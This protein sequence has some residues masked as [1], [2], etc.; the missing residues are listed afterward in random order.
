MNEI[1][2]V[3]EKRR[4]FTSSGVEHT[5]EVWRFARWHF[6]IVFWRGL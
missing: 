5:W 6:K 2:P 4:K 3:F 1:W